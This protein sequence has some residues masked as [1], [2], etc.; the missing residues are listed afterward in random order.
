[1]SERS[2]ASIVPNHPLASW[3]DATHLFERWSRNRRVATAAQTAWFIGRCLNY[4][5]PANI[6]AELSDLLSCGEID[7]LSVTRLSNRCFLTPAL[8]MGLQCKALS[9]LLPDDL[10]SYLD[11]I[12]SH[13][14]R[15]N[16]LIV[17]QA[18]EFFEALNS[19]GI[20]PI[21]LK[22]GLSLFET[23]LHEGLL[24]MADIDVLLPEDEFAQ[25]CRTLRSLGYITF[26]D[27]THNAHALTFHKAGALATVDLHR[28]VGPQVRLLTIAD[29]RQ[30]A[31]GFTSHNLGLAGI[32]ATHRVLLSLMNYCLFESQYRNRELPL[33]G[34]HNLAVVCRQHRHRIDWD[35]VSHAVHRNSLEAAARSWF[36]MA[37][38]LLFV[39]IPHALCTD[40]AASRHLCLCL[41]QL[42]FP[43]LTRVFRSGTRLAW[44]FSAWRMDYRYGCGLRGWPLAATRLRHAINVLLKR[45]RLAAAAPKQ[46]LLS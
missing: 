44:V 13:N 38:Q 30:S 17:A 1:L 3:L 14:R 11:F 21:L 23:D 7:W 27:M 39:P 5:G 43:R 19:R 6:R 12:S 40:R 28:H 33:R 4:D 9:Y 2:T 29:A 16:R 42:N 31:I 35:A 15:R 46:G 45:L 41:L 34:L 24:M 20:C 8:D 36:N 32:S 37:R 10:R 26:G 22:G 25:G 18:I